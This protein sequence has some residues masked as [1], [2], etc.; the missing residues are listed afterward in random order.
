MVADTPS[1]R[2]LDV[3][4]CVEAPSKTDHPVP[5]PNLVDP[6]DPGDGRIPI[7]T[8]LLKEG[9]GIGTRYR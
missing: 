2:E 6:V 1:R 5:K 9:R 8:G 7:C 4:A 3:L